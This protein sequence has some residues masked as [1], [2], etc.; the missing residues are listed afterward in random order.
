MASVPFYSLEVMHS[1]IKSEVDAALRSVFANNQFILGSEVEAFEREFAEYSGVGYCV[2][3]ANG[4]D[5]LYVSLK[6]LGIGNG[7]EVIVPAHTYI[8]TWLA[9]ARVGATIVPVDVDP[10]TMLV[11]AKE[12]EAAITKRTK[13]ILP[14]HLYGNACDMSE[15]MQ[16]ANKYNLEVVEDNAQAQGATHT[17]KNT[18][19]FGRCNATSFYPSKNLG[20]LGDAGAITTDDEQLYN[21]AKIYCNYG[22]SSRFE[23][24]V[25]GINSRLDEIQAAVLR[26][27]LRHLEGW[28]AKR[29]KIA[30][31]YH[32]NL[33]G[34]DAVTLP[35]FG[36][37][38][39]P[40]LYVIRASQRDQLRNYLSSKEVETSIHYPKPPHLQTAFSRLGM[41]Q[42]Q[43]PI[44]ES[45]AETELSLPLWPGI[46]ED[47][48]DKVCDAVKQFYG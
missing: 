46:T 2:G 10:I 40:H 35:K 24:P 13:A 6:L 4:L 8:A 9:I 28:N 30:D 26:I 19:S 39:A 7:D 41:K 45:I 27:K 11:G 33:L 18:G 16:L 12:I 20:S 43:F 29:R 5:A 17:S 36:E 37:G 47:Q 38:C 42:G 32:K 48:I 3:V 44:S 25:Q 34:C 15:I 21:A 31:Q 14:V 1:Q 23:N 22:S